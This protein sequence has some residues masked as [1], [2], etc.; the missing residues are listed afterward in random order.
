MG[1]PAFGLA[2]LVATGPVL[3]P[4]SIANIAFTDRCRPPNGYLEM[5]LQLVLSYQI[6]PHLSNNKART[7]TKH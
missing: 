2:S 1:R 7:T 4:S 6:S 5:N 3:T